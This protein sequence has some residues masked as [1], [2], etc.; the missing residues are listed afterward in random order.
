MGLFWLH[1]IEALRIFGLFYYAL[2]SSLA[3][4]GDNQ[5]QEM[6]RPTF[7]KIRLVHEFMSGIRCKFAGNTLVDQLST[8]MLVG[9]RLTSL[10][11]APC[12]FHL[13]T[14]IAILYWKFLGY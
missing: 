13:D 11:M 9:M 2:N 8:F 3:W 12:S 14:V 4:I 5:E 7:Y 6:F 1:S 10:Q